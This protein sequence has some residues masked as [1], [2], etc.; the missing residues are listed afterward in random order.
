[1]LNRSPRLPRAVGLL[2]TLAFA[3]GLLLLLAGQGGTLIVAADGKAGERLGHFQPLERGEGGLPFRWT[4][5]ASSVVSPRFAY[6]ERLTLT[7]NGSRPPAFAASPTDLY[8]AGK[9]VAT[10]PASNTL[11]TYTLDYADLALDPELSLELRPQQTFYPSDKDY[12]ELGIVF[13]SLKVEAA[14]GPIGLRWPSSLIV[15]LWLLG[16]GMVWA[17]AR[18]RFGLAVAGSVVALGLAA[19]LF[20]GVSNRL[21]LL[22]IIVAYATVAALLSHRL[23]VEGWL[24]SAWARLGRLWPQRLRWAGPPLFYF[25]LASVFTWPYVLHLGE[26]LPGWPMDNFNFLYKIWWVGHA[27]FGNPPPGSDLAYNPNVYYPAGFNLAQGELTP[28]NTMLTLPITATLGPVW[29]YNVAQFASFVLSG[30][31]MY[32]LVKYLLAAHPAL[33]REGSGGGEEETASLIALFAGLIYAFAPWHLNQMM[34]HLQM[35][36]IQWFPLT[37]LFVEK[38][39]RERRWQDGL[40]AGVF[41]SLCA[42]QAWYF[43]AI[44]GVMVGLYGVVR[45]VMVART[46]PPT[47]RAPRAGMRR[48]LIAFGAFGAAVLAMVL[49]FLIPYLQLRGQAKLAYTVKAANGSSA[50]PSDYFMPSQLHPLWGDRFLNAHTANLNITDYNVYLGIVPLLLA[51]LAFVLGGQAERGLR[52]LWLVVA[53]VAAVFSFGLLLD[54]GGELERF[55]YVQPAS[56]VLWPLPGLLLFNYVPGFNGVRAYARFGVIVILAVAVLAAYGLRYLLQRPRFARHGF[57]TV[58]L[59]SSLLLVEWWAN[60][61]TFGYSKAFE[62]PMDRWLAAQPGQ[63]TVAMFSVDRSWK[64]GPAMWGS[65]YHGKRIAYGYET[66][67]PPLYTANEDALNQFPD[68]QAINLIAAA[69]FDAKYVAVSSRY[70]GLDYKSA[71]SWPQVRDSLAANP[72]LRLVQ[73]FKQAAMWQG[74]LRLF[75]RRPDIEWHC[76]PD[77]IYLYEVVK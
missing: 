21:L 2:L 70:P 22:T 46:Q 7:L 29:S 30:W 27:L 43:A 61:Y 12:R 63:F 69:P 47:G 6:R 72:R 52:W 58:L 51:V 1:L 35:M 26:W 14:N 13:Y 20:A 68:P 73:V 17:L 53:L 54:V 3:L 76:L 33:R 32:L 25:G 23:A 8:L 36:G 11:F 19:Y 50:L 59:L 5:E 49:P 66:F 75:D 39:I 16:A 28:V 48:S 10:I 24:V 64:D 15:G 40:L 41:F 4:K 38:L 9:L 60:P 71:K 62:Q 34:G 65:V 44:A 42:W 77:D 55:G 45:L 37:F 18:S 74:D 56:G 57:L 67:V 31:G